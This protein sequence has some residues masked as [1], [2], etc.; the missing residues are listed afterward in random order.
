MT[1]R[2]QARAVRRMGELYKSFNAQGQRSDQLIEGTHNKLT[3][4]EVRE[5]V[6]LSHHQAAQAVRVANVPEEKF[7]AKR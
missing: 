3:Q 1:D 7:E 2:I 5:S 4:K 6:G